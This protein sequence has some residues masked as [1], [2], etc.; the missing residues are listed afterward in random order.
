M[1]CFSWKCASFASGQHG[2]EVTV[3]VRGARCT[4]AAMN[5]ECAVHPA[6]DKLSIRDTHKLIRIIRCAE[7]CACCNFSFNASAPEEEEEEEDKSGNSPPLAVWS[8]RFIINNTSDTQ[9]SKPQ[10]KVSSVNSVHQ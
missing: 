6:H 5:H 4:C 10:R 9:N 1:K 7:A 2:G 8:F 3:C